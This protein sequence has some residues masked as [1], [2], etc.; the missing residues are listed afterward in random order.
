MQGIAKHAPQQAYEALSR[1]KVNSW[2]ALNSYTHAG[3]HAIQ[4]HHDGYPSELLQDL[5]R[6][7]N[8][9]A[10]VACMQAVSLSGKQPLQSELLKIAGRF[11]SCMPPPL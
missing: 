6:N 2:T 5:L 9:L 8:G 3:I 7:A 1:F 10:V 4:R 11:P